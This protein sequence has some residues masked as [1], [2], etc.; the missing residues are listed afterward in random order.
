MSKAIETGTMIHLR[1]G[2][3]IVKS[4]RSSKMRARVNLTC[5]TVKS[6]E[7]KYGVTLTSLKTGRH[8]KLNTYHTIGDAWKLY[9]SLM[10]A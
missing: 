9:K 2:L 4:D 7:V 8:M 6:G 3:L 10:T 1:N 5:K